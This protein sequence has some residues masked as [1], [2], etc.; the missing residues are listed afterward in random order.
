MPRISTR[1]CTALTLSLIAAGPGALVNGCAPLPAESPTTL[2]APAAYQPFRAREARGLPPE[3]R[4]DPIDLGDRSRFVR[5]T[6]EATIFDTR[7]V[8]NQRQITEPFTGQIRMI[9]NEIEEHENRDRGDDAEDRERNLERDLDRDR[10]RRER[11]REE[12]EREE[13]ERFMD[14]PHDRVD[15]PAPV[16]RAT[17]TGRVVTRGG[18]GFAAVAQTE[19][20]P[21]DPNLAVGP[22]HIVETVNAAIAFYDKH[23]G[24]QLFSTHLGTPGNPGFFEPVG[25]DSGF[26][27]DPKCFYDQKVGRFVVVALEHNSNDS[28]I[29]I[30]VSDDDDPNGIWYK[31]RTFSVIALGSSQY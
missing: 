17:E 12:H 6:V 30:A 10:D 25:A 31:Y 27:F 8:V 13:R 15:H 2:R 21:P 14:L 22:D 4:P 5:T 20:S 3:L 11:E 16:G 1:H 7:T 9:E 29:D 24:Q 18:S 26:V 23:T 28:W 19:W